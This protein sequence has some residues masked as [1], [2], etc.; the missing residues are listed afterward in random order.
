VPV[1]RDERAARAAMLLATR[2]EE[3]AAAAERATSAGEALLVHRIELAQMST[4]HAIDL[5]LMTTSEAAQIWREAQRRHPAL[6]ELGRL[7][8][9]E[10][11]TALPPQAAVREHLA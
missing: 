1:T 2:L 11:A 7:V 4:R 10:A 8:G 3:L 6:A 5:G 9:E